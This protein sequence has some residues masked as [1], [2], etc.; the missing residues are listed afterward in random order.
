MA[1]TDK[2][3][4]E[5]VRT[6]VREYLDNRAELLGSRRYFT[7]QFR[8]EVHLLRRELRW[9]QTLNTILMA[10]ILSILVRNTV[11]MDETMTKSFSPSGILKIAEER[12]VESGWKVRQRI[13]AA[14]DSAELEEQRRQ[15][16][17]SS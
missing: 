5:V 15:D 2:R 4:A 6:A 11:E 12:M 16:K 7:G 9:H 17:D 1:G 8:D 14:A 3:I 10:E 13:E